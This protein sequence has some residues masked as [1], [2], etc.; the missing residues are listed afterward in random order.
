[1]SEFSWFTLATSATTQKL[2]EA[3]L[4]QIASQG[5]GMTQKEVLY[6]PHLL[7]NV[8]RWV[9]HLTIY[10]NENLPK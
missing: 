10:S 5:V 9:D 7:F 8:T 2:I 1:M 3:H 6:R 4:S